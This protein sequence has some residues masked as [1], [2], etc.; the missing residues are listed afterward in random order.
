MKLSLALLLLFI[1]TV[2]TA[3]L[4]LVYFDGRGRGEQHRLFFAD[5]QIAYTDQRLTGAQFM[6]IKQSLPWGHVPVLNVSGTVLADTAA[7]NVYLGRQYNLWPSDS[8]TEQRL[9][10]YASASEDLREQKNEMIGTGWT[11]VSPDLQRKFLPIVQDWLFYF[12]RNLKSTGG[13]PYL[14]GNLFTPVDCRVWDILDQIA[15]CMSQYPNLYD[16]YPMTSGFRKAVATRPNIAQ[17]LKNRKL[18]V[19]AVVEEA[20]N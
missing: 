2:F 12:E 9:V 18:D 6:K 20:E 10:A 19:E 14:C 5:Q 7:L 3:N 8:F 11:P 16:N 1:S 17:Y 15:G 13:S 4:V